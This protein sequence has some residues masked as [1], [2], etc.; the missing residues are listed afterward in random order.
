M[1]AGARYALATFGSVDGK[2]SR[3][4]QLNTAYNS[5]MF[6]AVLSSDHYTPA[7]GKTIAIKISKAGGGFANPSAGATNATEVSNGWYFF[8]LSAADISVLGD[9]AVYGAEATVD[10]VAIDCQVIDPSAFMDI[11][12]GVE[13]GL[14][15]RNAL[16]GLSAML[17]GKV[18]G[19]QSGTEIFREAVSDTK[20]RVT[21]FDD[22][23]GNRTNIITD[24]T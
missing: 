11:P 19:A 2:V 10:D 3:I 22:T 17:F 8:A 4:L 5:L 24:F 15:V 23:S 9:L 14:T 20:A 21:V 12:N 6:R 13:A 18:T 16:R 7:T 1:R